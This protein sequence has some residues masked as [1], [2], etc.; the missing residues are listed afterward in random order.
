MAIIPSNQD[1]TQFMGS[2]IGRPVNY[3]PFGA[4]APASQQPQ[5]QPS[6]NFMQMPN[7]NS[8][9][10]P[11]YMQGMQ[12]LMSGMRPQM[13]MGQSPWMNRSGPTGQATMNSMPG[14]S[15]MHGMF[16]R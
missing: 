10:P 8:M 9:L 1:V 11:S 13:Q 4:G 3:S 15:M 6:S 5:S 14:M 12:S 16:G 2:G 7:P